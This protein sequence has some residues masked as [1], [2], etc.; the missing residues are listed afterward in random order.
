MIN[1]NSSKEIIIFI[2]SIESGG[3]EKNLFIILGFLSKHYSRI[4]LVTSS[5]LNLFNKNRRVNIIKPRSNFWI[6]KSRLVKSIICLF[7]LFKFFPKN[8]FVVFSFQSNFFSILASK[9]RGWPIILRLNTSPQKYA[10]NF[11]KII[12]FKTLYKLS[13]EI[14]V[15]SKEFRKNIKKIFGL[16]SSIIYN[17]ILYRKIRQKE[18]KNLNNYRGL[19]ILN[20]ARLTDQKD[21]LTLFKS[22]KYILD[23]KKIDLKLFV[24]GRGKNN[25]ILKEYIKKHNLKNYIILLGYKKN[26]E[27]Y[28]K[29]FDLFVLSSRYEGLPNTLIEAQ[30]SEL[31]IISSD[32]PSGP[33]EILMNGKLGTLFKTG[34][35]KD[36]SKK[37]LL[38]YYDKKKFEIK[39][40]RAKKYLN[41]FDYY[42]NLNSFLK[43]INKYI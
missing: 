33:K 38:F 5:K 1:Y 37:I 20:V 35:Y 17:S 10:N 28:M 24:I 2:P 3:V 41:R 15:N 14:I 21:H 26:A 25:L 31:P 11:F 27:K 22:I 42:K 43:I 18:I 12:F 29:S 4:N 19:K 13:D 36:L 23:K 16:N 6:N 39:A 40:I 32:C 7:L 8:R 9:L 34:N 30:I